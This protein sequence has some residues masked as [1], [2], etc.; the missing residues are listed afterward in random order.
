MLCAG[1]AQGE[2]LVDY[3]L[4]TKYGWVGEQ[5]SCQWLHDGAN[6]ARFEVEVEHFENRIVT[7]LQVPATARA[8]TFTPSRAGHYRCQV[9]GCNEA[10]CSQWHTSD[11]R[12]WWFFVWLKPPGF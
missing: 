11:S 5:R 7:A 12:G 3:A 10:G 8:A 4:T 1:V 6:V 9:R 2:P